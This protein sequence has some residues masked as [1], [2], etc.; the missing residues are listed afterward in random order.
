VREHRHPDEDRRR[1]RAGQPAG[2]APAPADALLS[3]QRAAGNRAVAGMLARDKDDKD[4]KAPEATATN[5]TTEL[6]DLGVIALDSARWDANG[7]DVHI[8]FAQSS[9]DAKV[10][11]AVADGRVLKPAWISSPAAKSTLTGAM[12]ATARL[13]GESTGAGFVYATVN[14]ETVDHD[15]VKR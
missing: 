3:L 13:A 15:F 8:V 1:E 11:Q 4:N 10:M 9:L 5:T 2:A 7:K 14:F 12:I 6:G